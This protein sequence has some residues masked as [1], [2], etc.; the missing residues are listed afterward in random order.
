M[1][2]RI[3]PEVDAVHEEVLVRLEDFLGFEVR[4]LPLHYKPKL[5]GGLGKF[6][7]FSLDTLPRQFVYSFE[8]S[9][10]EPHIEILSALA[11]FGLDDFD[12]GFEIPGHDLC[13][14]MHVEQGIDADVMHHFQD[15]LCHEYAHYVFD[16]DFLETVG[17][18]MQTPEESARQ[19]CLRIFSLSPFNYPRGKGLCY[20]NK[21]LGLLHESEES[22]NEHK[23]RF[24]EYV[25]LLASPS[26]SVNE[27]FSFWVMDKVRGHRHFNPEIASGYTRDWDR[28]LPTKIEYFYDSIEG[29]SGRQGV[30]F[31]V[32]N[33]AQLV[34]TLKEDLIEASGDPQGVAYANFYR[35]LF[36]QP[37]PTCA[38]QPV[39][40][41]A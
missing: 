35:V 25:F 3:S 39:Y 6:S 40:S 12:A 19:Y 5:G 20:D 14:K 29:W 2:F 27:A 11:D 37:I 22:L 28:S 30:D 4:K 9:F 36:R 38:Q 15:T 1:S 7:H 33:L 21:S 31:V 24:S 26:L 18:L 34:K 32:N 41:V 23:I 17:K 13:K 10:E 8:D 16:R